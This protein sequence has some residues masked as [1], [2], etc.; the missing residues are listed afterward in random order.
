MLMPGPGY[1]NVPGMNKNGRYPSSTNRNVQFIIL[2]RE[3]SIAE[4]QDNNLGPGACKF[5]I[6]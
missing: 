2:D 4:K 3:K 5:K 6:R 1:Y